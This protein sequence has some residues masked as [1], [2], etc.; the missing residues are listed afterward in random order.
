MSSPARRLLDFYDLLDGLVESRLDAIQLRRLE[1]YVAD[2]PELR[3]RYVL[4]IEWH[5][6]AER[7]QGWVRDQEGSPSQQTPHA[8]APAR[9]RLH[10]TLGWFQG[11]SLGWTITMLAAASLVGMLLLSR[12]RV[13]SPKTPRIEAAAAP[14]VAASFATLSRTADCTWHDC[15]LPTQPGSRLGAGWLRLETGVAELTF[16]VG[17]TVILQAPSEF[18]LEGRMQSALRSGRLTCRVG[19]EAHGFRVATPSAEIVDLGTEFGVLASEGFSEVHVFRGAVE[20]R[21]RGSAHGP[22]P[23]EL[24]RTGQAKRLEAKGAGLAASQDRLEGPFGLALTRD[25]RLLIAS[26]FTDAL[27]NCSL[28]AGNPLSALVPPRHGD[29]NAPMFLALGPDELLYV[30]SAGNHS[31]L[32]YT[33]DGEFL[34]AFVGPRVGAL[35]APTGLAFGSDG[36]LY[37]ASVGKRTVF[38]F[39]G[40]TGAPLGMLFDPGEGGIEAPMG[41][42]FDRQGRLFVA[43]PMG[44]AVFAFAPDGTLLQRWTAPEIRFPFGLVLD[45][46]QR[47]VV[48]CRDSDRLVRI[49]P[50]APLGQQIELFDGPQ[51]PHG[52]LFTPA[53]ELLVT[54]DSLN[55]VL[56]YD[57]HSIE[58]IDTLVNGWR[59]VPVDELAFIRSLPPRVVAD[60]GEDRHRQPLSAGAHDPAWWIHDCP[61]PRFMTWGPAVATEAPTGWPE[62]NGARWISIAPLRDG[63]RAA[64]GDYVFATA[65]D[66]SQP[67]GI[68]EG[69]LLTTSPIVEV[70]VNRVG[71]SAHVELP[72]ARHLRDKSAGRLRI[73]TELKPTGNLVEFVLRHDGQG[74]VGMALRWGLNPTEGPEAAP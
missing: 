33:L 7:Y 60:T 6:L 27:L 64:Q 34:G 49:D 18:A 17:A 30:S 14:A 71:T 40:A 73:E 57:G 23:V 16:D 62:P 70:R 53:G 10:R 12:S 52:V 1:H 25:G 37:A 13:D 31:I 22:V 24:L 47:I 36:H 56:R 43:D 11:R 55:S 29:L 21:P 2:D 68:L 61:D 8:G 46:R 35:A 72:D 28:D 74:P 32:R 51:T 63:D 59:D 44:H 3:R 45:D 58:Y 69:E 48:S 9:M 50:A 66:T 20:V 65:F 67:R 54:S 39:D 5:A 26:R 15:T 42:A 41:M 4:F 38:R 19:P